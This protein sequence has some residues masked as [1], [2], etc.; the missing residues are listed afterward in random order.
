MD[1]VVCRMGDVLFAYRDSC[2][3]WGAPIAGA[4][5]ERRLGSGPRTAV[6]TCPACSGHFVVERAGQGLDNAAE[7]LDPLPVLMRNSV[8]EVAVPTGVPA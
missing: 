8:F 3:R 7:H 5:V 6:L 4:A 1:I 2:G